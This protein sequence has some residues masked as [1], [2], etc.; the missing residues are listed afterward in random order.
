MQAD[1]T[2][3][4]QNCQKLMNINDELTKKIKYLEQ[5]DSFLQ[6]KIHSLEGSWS[7]RA[8]VTFA[9]EWL[10][11]RKS[12]NEARQQLCSLKSTVSTLAN[13]EMQKLRSV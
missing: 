4:R 2:M 6:G 5:I 12:L 7:G 10:R 8:Q 9:E 11:A 13:Q 3:I 1:G